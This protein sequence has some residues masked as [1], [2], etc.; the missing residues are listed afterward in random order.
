MI[1]L[2]T[3][4]IRSI[5]TVGMT[6]TRKT[7]RDFEEDFNWIQT[8]RGRSDWYTVD[9]FYIGIDQ[10][11]RMSFARGKLSLNPFGGSIEYLDASNSHMV[12]N[13]DEEFLL[14]ASAVSSA[15]VPFTRSLDGQSSTLSQTFSHGIH[16]PGREHWKYPFGQVILMQSDGSSAPSSRMIGVKRDAL[17]R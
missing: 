4:F 11:I 2:A 3:L 14:Q 16:F 1:V 12:M 9:C 8:R 17:L 15:A 13:D 5:T 7:L 6:T 10:L